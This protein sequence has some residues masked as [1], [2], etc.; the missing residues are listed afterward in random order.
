MRGLQRI[1]NEQYHTFSISS[2]SLYSKLIPLN[3]I[4]IFAKI[5][6]SFVFLLDWCVLINFLYFMIT[7]CLVE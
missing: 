1:K 5:L 4:K 6:C 2:S 3:K 7:I